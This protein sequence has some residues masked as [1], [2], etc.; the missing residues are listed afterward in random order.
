MI[1]MVSF[2]EFN[3]YLPFSKKL[4]SQLPYKPACKMH[5]KRLQ[6]G[7]FGHWKPRYSL[8]MW[9]WNKKL[10]VCFRFKNICLMGATE[11]FTACMTCPKIKTNWSSF[12]RE[13]FT[14][15]IKIG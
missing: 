11:Q 14:V 8:T 7:E 1:L 9:H 2:R 15:A 3:Y 12:T 4:L 10:H 13:W 5:S 6:I